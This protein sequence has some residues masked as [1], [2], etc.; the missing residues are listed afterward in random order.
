MINGADRSDRIER[1]ISRA[2]GTAGISTDSGMDARLNTTHHSPYGYIAAG[3]RSRRP[4]AAECSRSNYS[5]TEESR[6]G[7]RLESGAPDWVLIIVPKLVLKPRASSAMFE[8][9]PDSGWVESRI[10]SKVHFPVSSDGRLF[11]C[12]PFFLCANFSSNTIR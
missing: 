11:L 12:L 4:F 10:S 3:C 9:S 5:L 7:C 1:G 6:P 2:R 8:L